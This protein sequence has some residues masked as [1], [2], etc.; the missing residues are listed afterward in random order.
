VCESRHVLLF[1]FIAT[2]VTSVTGWACGINTSWPQ[3]KKG[4]HSAAPEFGGVVET[5]N[6]QVLFVL[7][8]EL[9]WFLLNFSSH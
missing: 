6:R 1:S 8:T 3:M 5:S 4:F 7:Y 2:D 9:L